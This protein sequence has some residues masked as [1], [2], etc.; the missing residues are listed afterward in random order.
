MGLWRA[1]VRRLAGREGL[2]ICE[3]RVVGGSGVMASSPKEDSLEESNPMVRELPVGEPSQKGFVGL[4][5]L[6]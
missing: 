3:C 5:S 2:A 4:C 6:V 1:K